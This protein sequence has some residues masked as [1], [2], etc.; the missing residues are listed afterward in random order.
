M[1]YFN[2]FL[3]YF[4]DCTIFLYVN[5]Q[6]KI[7]EIIYFVWHCLENH[8]YK[9]IT[10]P[11]YSASLTLSLHVCIRVLPRHEAVYYTISSSIYI[12]NNIMIVNKIN[13]TFM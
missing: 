4:V 6:L 8:V 1:V 13:N 9:L 3:Y 2:F 10:T 7:T 12:H 11:F 5:V